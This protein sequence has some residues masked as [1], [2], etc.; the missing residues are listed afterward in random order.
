[1]KNGFLIL[2]IS[3][4]IFISGCWDQKIYEQIGFMLQV[5]MEKSKTSEDILITYTSPVIGTDEKGRIEILST[6]AGILR[7]ARENVRR[8]SARTLEGGKVQ[9][10]LIS[11]ELAKLGIHNLTEIFERDPHNP[12]LAWIVITEGSPLEI[13]EKAAD[14]KD[15][16][17][18]AIYINQL[19]ESNV[20]SSYI[21]ETRIYD[22]KI[23]YFAEG[24]DPTAPLIK[25]TPNSVMIVGSA[26]FSGD[27]MV[28]KID[29]QKTALMVSMRGML[30]RSEYIA[31]APDIAEAPK[32]KRLEAETQI[33][34]M[35]MGV[36]RKISIDIEDNKPVVKIFLDFE[37]TLDEF[38]WDKTGELSVQ[39]K[40]EEHL[41]KHIKK[42][43]T[44]LVKYLQEIESDP[45]GIGDLVRAKHNDYW[46]DIE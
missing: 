14:F 1:M 18:P 42:E 36:K 39:H 34:V 30:R 24:I 12:A 40:I 8:Q 7:G 46:K 37:A 23:I 41:E 19:M 32:G 11:E 44:E 5:G 9:Q 21:P 29:H 28:G 45:I 31:P 35:L 17:R 25:L 3:S 27:K 16:P 43:C 33:A 20:K 6:T 26:L 15:K 22:F 38:K 2:L 4:S 10:V 13:F